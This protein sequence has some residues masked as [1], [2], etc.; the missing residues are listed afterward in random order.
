[1]RTLT[2]RE[3]VFVGAYLVLNT[4]VPCLIPDL[5][6]FSSQPMFSGFPERMSIVDIHDEDGRPLPPQPFSLESRELFNPHPRLGKRLP[7]SLLP[8]GRLMSDAEVRAAVI[9]VL[10]SKYPHLRSVT[11]HQQVFARGANLN[12]AERIADQT[13]HIENL[14]APE[15]VR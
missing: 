13:W 6:P 9:P 3:K 8:S 15:T 5:F 10:A 12:K 14:M 1:M 4:V 7:P 2:L 11:V